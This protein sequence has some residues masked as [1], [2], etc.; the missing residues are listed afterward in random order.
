MKGTV[1][2]NED[3][4]RSYTKLQPSEVNSLMKQTIQC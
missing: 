2:S 1:L 4:V 3:S